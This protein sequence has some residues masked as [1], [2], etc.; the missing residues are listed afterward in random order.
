MRFRN[1]TMQSL[2]QIRIFG[3]IKVGT[4]E[5]LAPHFLCLALKLIV[6]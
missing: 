4:L 3:T 6:S 1:F 2:E 5:K